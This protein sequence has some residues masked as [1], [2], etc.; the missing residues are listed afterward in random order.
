MLKKLVLILFLLLTPIIA[1]S[2]NSADKIYSDVYDITYYIRPF[3][4]PDIEWQK[5]EIEMD[6]PHG[7]EL[8]KIKNSFEVILRSTII[9]YDRD[10]VKKG[11]RTYKEQLI[12]N[13]KHREEGFVI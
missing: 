7:L 3:F 8:N 10:I 2:E 11:E 1:H 5:F 4:V 6:Y 9:F 13:L 12:E